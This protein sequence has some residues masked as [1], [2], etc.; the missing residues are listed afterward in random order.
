MS[1]VLSGCTTA[2]FV[3]FAVSVWSK[4][5]SPA[6]HRLFVDSLR[7]LRFLPA[8]SLALVAVLAT[9]A[10][11]LVATALGCSLVTVLAGFPMW[12]PALAAAGILVLVLTIGVVLAIR[13]G[14]GA[15]CACFG[16]AE[17]PLGRRHVLRNILLFVIAVAGLVTGDS[18]APA[19]AWA[20]LGCAAGVVVAL[21]LI[22]LDEL[23]D[24]FV[25][26]LTSRS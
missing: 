23:A 24:L 7:P 6:A 11:A 19:P 12:F 10:E 18:A 16:A 17:R 5:R 15:R 14:T 26:V 25:P 2:L 8:K 13:E 9:G 21:I 4:A 22:R 3:V 20:A 1:A